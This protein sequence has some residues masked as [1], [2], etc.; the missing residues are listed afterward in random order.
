MLN[1]DL[2]IHSV[3]S[4][5]GEFSVPDIIDKCLLSG[6]EV[7]SITDHNSVTGVEEAIE[8]GSAKKLKV[9]P[10][11]EIDCIYKGIDLHLLGYNINHLSN[12][13]AEL[14]ETV[15]KKIMDSVPRMIGNLEKAGIHVDQDEVMEKAGNQLPSAELMAEV[16]LNNVK[17]HNNRL[18]RPYMPGGN[19]SDMP[20]INFYLD[21][22][23]QGKP[24]YDKIEHISF[25]EA[26]EL[27]VSNGG[28]AIVAHPGANLRGQETMITELLD[29]G[30]AGLEVF[31]NYH[32]QDQIKYFCETGEQ[33]KAILTCGSDFHGKNK[34]L[35]QPGKFR[36]NEDYLDY[37]ERGI[38]MLTDGRA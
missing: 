19:R 21:Y 24:A 38:R 23:A 8:Y 36:M 15:E 22:F 17:Y 25:E 29:G 31:N 35:I 34:P 5:D 27:V 18:L 4:N 11:I 16:L 26:I 33:R 7:I 10:G 9:L 12:D 30:A 32:E 1:A 13:F 28:T 37:V 6:L 3:H 20:Y 2:H 14:Q